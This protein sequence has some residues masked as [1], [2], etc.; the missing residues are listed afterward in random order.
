MSSP[1]GAEL[2]RAIPFAGCL[3]G[4]PVPSPTLPLHRLTSGFPAAN[5]R[6]DSGSTSPVA[7]LA[8]P[9]A[10]VADLP[11]CPARRPQPPVPPLRLPGS[12]SPTPS[13]GSPEGSQQRKQIIPRPIPLHLVNPVGPP[14]H[15]DR[16]CWLPRLAGTVPR[17]PVGV[18]LP[19]CRPSCTPPPARSRGIFV[20]TG[21]SA[22]KRG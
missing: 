6:T 17:V 15:R 11:G 19:V 16:H 13:T 20:P 8:S 7:R 4:C 2:R 10:A 9:G 14:P 18:R 12:V 21:L 5:L 3:P 22:E 1:V